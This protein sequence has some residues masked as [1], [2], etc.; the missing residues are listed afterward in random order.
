METPLKTKSDDAL[1]YASAI[2]QAAL[3][4]S[5]EIS[6]VELV[7][8]HLDR[9]AKLNPTLGAYILV[10]EEAALADARKADDLVRAR[11]AEELPAFCGVPTSIKGAIEVAG[12]PTSWS[13]NAVEAPLAGEDA[14]PVRRMREAGFVILG[15]T[16]LPEMSMG[17]SESWANGICRNPWN[18]E[19]DAGGSS[20]GAGVATAAGL[21]AIALGAD[22]GGSIRNPASLN[23]VVGLKPARGRVSC[24]PYL[25]EMIAG[26]GTD[27]PL[28]RTVRDAAA[29]LD[30]IGRYET[31]DP[32][33][34][35]APAQ[36]F[37]SEPGRGGK[38]RVAVATDAAG[39]IE[40][41]PDGIAAAE[42]AAKIVESLGHHVEVAT[43]DWGGLELIH[44]A[45]SVFATI[46]ATLAGVSPD[47]YQKLE[48]R[49]RAVAEMA[50]KVSAAD[51]I[52]AVMELHRFSRRFVKFFDDYDVV[53]SPTLG[54]PP[55]RLGTFAPDSDELL[56]V[57]G[58]Q[59][60]HFTLPANVTG[61]PAI[62]IPLWWNSDKMP[63]GVQLLGRPADEG[64][65]LR[66][67]AELEVACPWADKRPPLK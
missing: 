50:Q 4:R 41:D 7:Q 36:P 6:S 19:Y 52:N 60:C 12:L 42:H 24:G 45:F 64:T 44:Q 13:T 3:V 66:L 21:G 49:N 46:A 63:I 26:L 57:K 11:P 23:G 10:T 65:I 22:G 28:A 37:A 8:A 32:Y 55:M 34:A 1:L 16:N 27:G 56:E 39:E 38:L 40:I 48:P 2:E 25:G 58:A 29:L 30:V 54:L 47:A 5:G 33:W 67:A 31:G 14:Y 62:S 15:K 35:P 43:P 51:Y 17:G 61:Q 20:S 59:A 53:L 18:L 9:I